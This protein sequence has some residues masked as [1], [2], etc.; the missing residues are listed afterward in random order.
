MEIIIEKIN[1]GFHAHCF[2]KVNGR[3]VNVIIDTGA[4]ETFLDKKFC[5]EIEIQLTECD[6]PY[7]TLTGEGNNAYSG[8]VDIELEEIKIPGAMVC[9]ESLDVVN[10]AYS[11][12]GINRIV[13]VLGL[14]ILNNFG[15]V[16][17]MRE[18]KILFDI[19]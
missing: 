10:K 5:E 13:G 16:I 1:S 9:V 2:I 19:K 7:S 8:K 18:K 3:R 17:N 12:F 14:D 4:S 15:A 11:S 6:S